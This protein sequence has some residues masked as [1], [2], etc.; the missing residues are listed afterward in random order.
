MGD[1]KE[2]FMETLID[3]IHA[4]IADY[5]RKNKETPI[6]L[7]QRDKENNFKI[8]KFPKKISQSQFCQAVWA[9]Q[10]D[11]P[12]DIF[13]ISY[14]SKLYLV[15]NTKFLPSDVLSN[16]LYNNKEGTPCS[17]I[18]QYERYNKEE[19]FYS[20]IWAAE[21]ENNISGSWKEFDGE[22]LAP[23]ELEEVF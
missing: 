10:E 12:E 22:T 8:Y 17:V 16:Q 15:D 3:Q 13:F 1:M 5:I 9:Y 14:P 11:D 4:T 6:L 7:F 19:I 18:V 2:L 20:R 21:V 23:L